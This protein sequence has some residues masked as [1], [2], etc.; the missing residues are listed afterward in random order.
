MNIF[1]DYEHEKLWN[2][3]RNKYF[4]KQQKFLIYFLLSM[5]EF[6]KTNKLSFVFPKPVVLLIIQNYFSLLIQEN[7][8]NNL[9]KK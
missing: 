5:K 1:C 3:K 2:V 8:E 6:I 9:K 4:P 7:K